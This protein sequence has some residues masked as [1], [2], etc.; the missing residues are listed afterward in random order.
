MNKTVK[1][2]IRDAVASTLSLSGLTSFS[3]LPASS[4]TILTF[5]RVLPAKLRANYP[6]KGLV[7]TPEELN[8]VLSIA[9]RY[10]DINTLSVAFRNTVN[11]EIQKPQ[12]AITFDD[13]QWDNLEYAVPILKKLKIPATFYI[14][15]AHIG[16]KNLLWHD[17][18]AFAW[19]QFATRRHEIFSKI[20]TESLP[21]QIF[22]CVSSFLQYLKSLNTNKRNG[23]IKQLKTF[24]IDFPEWARLMDWN[25]IKH[26]HEQHHEIGS[27]A[28]T[29]ALLSQLSVEAQKQELKQSALDIENATGVAPRSLC[30]PDGNYNKDT[31][32][33]LDDCQYQ[34]AVT[35]KWGINRTI[36]DPFQLLRC[37]ISSDHLRD[38]EGVLSKPRFQ[39]RLSKYHPKI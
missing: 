7:V 31:L 4:L 28:Q 13:G 36:P 17:E 39:F 8:W 34:T 38:S 1:A 26:I 19:Q 25:E 33:L 29:H 20:T 10:F 5:H 24:D 16:G 2:K 30:Y 6:L 15:T 21:E 35:T 23:F 12:L 14:P 32:N 18:A 3:L 37:D 27:H 22:N 9:I 11:V